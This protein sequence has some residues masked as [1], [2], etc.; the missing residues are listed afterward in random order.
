MEEAH[1]CGA[2]T[3]DGKTAANHGE[4]G[5]KTAK[6]HPYRF[7]MGPNWVGPWALVEYVWKLRGNLSFE[8]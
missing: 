7:W 6:T 2:T 4:K 8:N 5:R 3:A 1:V